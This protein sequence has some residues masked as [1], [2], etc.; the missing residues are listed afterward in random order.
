MFTSYSVSETENRC[1]AVGLSF[2]V[3][4]SSCKKTIWIQEVSVG[5]GFPILENIL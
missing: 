2:V 3:G 4:P 1:S 5:V